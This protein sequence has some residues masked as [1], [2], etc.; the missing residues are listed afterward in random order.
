MFEQVVE[1]QNLLPWVLVVVFHSRRGGQNPRKEVLRFD[2]LIKHA[3]DS[4]LNKQRG[5][6]TS[7]DRISLGRFF[8]HQLTLIIK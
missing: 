6:H 4:F 8:S 5:N 2:Y 3:T 1:P 7:T